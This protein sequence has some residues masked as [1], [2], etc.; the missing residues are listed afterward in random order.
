M[1]LNRHS[2]WKRAIFSIDVDRKN[3]PL[4]YEPFKL[5]VI[6]PTLQ[7]NKFM[8]VHGKFGFRCIGVQDNG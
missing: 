1:S 3:Q 7:D 8:Q 5:Y 6:D 4:L 2:E